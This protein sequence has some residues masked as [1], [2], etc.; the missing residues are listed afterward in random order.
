MDDPEGLATDTLPW[1]LA[2]VLLLEAPALPNTTASV[3]PCVLATAIGTP[4]LCKFSALL[5]SPRFTFMLVTPGV[6][7]VMMMPWGPMVLYS[8]LFE[9]T[10]SVLVPLPE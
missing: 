7:A 5:P 10:V 6:Y 4:L 9:L 1:M 3:P 2:S 8:T